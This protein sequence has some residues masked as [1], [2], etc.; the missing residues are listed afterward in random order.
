[1]LEIISSNSKGFHKNILF[2]LLTELG[3]V[4]IVDFQKRNGLTADGLF[5]MMSYNKL[6]SILLKVEA[7]D[8]EVPTGGGYWAETGT[9]CLVVCSRSCPAPSYSS[10]SS[11]KGS[12]IS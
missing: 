1:M 10:K 7:V 3:Y 4:D 12:S 5:G 6:Y 9:G 11:S 2:N 8:F